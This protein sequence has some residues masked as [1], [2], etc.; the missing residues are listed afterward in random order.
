MWLLHYNLAKP[1]F[2]VCVIRS[3]GLVD[4]TF[5]SGVVDSGLIIF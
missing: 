1:V 2:I 3:N 5:A 4:R